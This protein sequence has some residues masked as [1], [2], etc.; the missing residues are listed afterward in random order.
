[1]HG[2]VATGADGRAL[3][4]AML[5]SD[6]RAV[7]QLA[8][9]RSLPGPLRVRRANPLT[10][11]MAGP[12]LAWL[13]EHEQQTYAATRW[14]LQPKDWLRAQLTGQLVAESSDAFGHLALRCPRRLVGRRGRRGA[15]LGCG[16]AGPVARRRRPVGG[17]VAAR[18][19]RGARPA[20]G[21]PGRSRGGRH[22]GRRAGLRPG[23]RQNRAADHRE[24]CPGR[25]PDV[26]ADAGV[27]P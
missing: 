9:Y 11:G 10:P 4:P 14:A 6:S 16:A 23:P 13:A 15:G 18:S 21:H 19:R 12:M 2:L 22:G 8:A 20:A 3:R 7:H 1:M 25:H 26:T 27:G 24:R 17:R 5:W